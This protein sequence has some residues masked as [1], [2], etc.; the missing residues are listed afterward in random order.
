MFRFQKQAQSL[1]ILLKFLLEVVNLVFLSSYLF[2]FPIPIVFF[3]H[4]IKH[5][6]VKGLLIWQLIILISFLRHLILNQSLHFKCSLVPINDPLIE[7]SFPWVH[8]LV[9]MSSLK[10]WVV[11]RRVKIVLFRI[12]L[13]VLHQYLISLCLE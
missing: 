12:K 1:G 13:Y 9:D 11:N 8:S 5:S 4:I 2:R 3:Q 7:L 10:F 6:V